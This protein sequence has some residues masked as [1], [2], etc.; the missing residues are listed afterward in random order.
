MDQQAIKVEVWLYG[1]LAQYAPEGGGAGHA[2]ILLDVPSGT[3]MSDLL[4]R[5]GLPLDE[6]GITFIN[7]QLTDMPG[8]GADL[9]WEF[10]EGDRVGIFHRRSMWPFQYRFGAN[11]SAALKDASKSRESNLIFHSSASVSSSEKGDK[12]G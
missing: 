7:G 8:L 12:K 9:D 1:P 2:Q 4:S 6:K 11:I 10:K 3:R 5:F